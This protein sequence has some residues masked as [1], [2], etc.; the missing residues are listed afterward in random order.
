MYFTGNGNTQVTEVGGGVTVFFCGNKIFRS[1]PSKETLTHLLETHK[2]IY[3]A[4][5]HPR[6]TRRQQ[7]TLDGRQQYCTAQKES[8]DVQSA[9]PGG[10]HR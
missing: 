3:I 8:N 2:K 5:Q 7:R 10:A 4:K 1:V 6:H 9:H